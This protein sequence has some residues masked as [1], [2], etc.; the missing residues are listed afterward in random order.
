MFMLPAILSILLWQYVP[1]VRGA[2]IGSFRAMQNIFVMTGGGPNRATHVM[3]FEIFQRAFIYV[4]FGYATAIGW[5]LA[6]MLITFTIYNLRILKNVRF[7]R[8][9]D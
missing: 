9:E 5:I 6:F 7:T 1:L 3:G 2:F 4:Q 8:A